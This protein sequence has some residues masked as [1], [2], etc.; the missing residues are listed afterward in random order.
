MKKKI[1]IHLSKGFSVAGNLHPI[2]TTA[3]SSL[4]ECSPPEKRSEKFIILGHRYY[5]FGEIYLY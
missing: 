4:V 1:M 3:R 2:S 5:V